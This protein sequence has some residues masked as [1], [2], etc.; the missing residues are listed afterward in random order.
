[1]GELIALVIGVVIGLLVGA[2]NSSKVKAELEDLKAK[3]RSK[4]G[5]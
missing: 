3:A 1:M 4:V 5:L 2:K